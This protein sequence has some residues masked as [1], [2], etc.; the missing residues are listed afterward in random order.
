M[1]GGRGEGSR[2]GLCLFLALP[3]AA[4]RFA[5]ERWAHKLLAAPELPAPVD[6]KDSA[7]DGR[8]AF[9]EGDFAFEK[10]V[11]PT[12]QTPG[13]HC[14]DDE[15]E[16]GSDE[17]ASM[18]AGAGAAGNAGNAVPEGEAS[19][20][21]EAKAVVELGLLGTVKQNPDGYLDGPT[22]HDDVTGTV[23]A[24][25][26]DHAGSAPVAPPKLRQIGRN[27]TFGNP[28]SGEGETGEGGGGGGGEGE[29]EGEGGGGGE[30]QEV[31][32]QF[33]GTVHSD[34][35]DDDDML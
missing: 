25:E 10:V 20:A 21:G 1:G 34:E 9:N 23:G 27:P 29:G 11:T 19:E 26:S 4:L 24:A 22:A 6:W 15:E 33:R 30:A 17:A 18:E 13:G 28:T 8:E 12:K 35:D 2:R 14:D 32:G 31:D 3:P 5:A 7:D 16:G